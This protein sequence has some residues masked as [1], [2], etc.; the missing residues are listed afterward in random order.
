MAQLVQESPLDIALDEELIGLTSSEQKQQML[1]QIKPD[2]IILKPSLIG[3]FDHS[4]Q[5]INWAENLGIGWWVTSALESNVG[6]NAIAQYAATKAIS[7]PQGLGTGSLYFNNI[8]APLRVQNAK[9]YY[10]LNQSW[11][12]NSLNL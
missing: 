2:Y 11:S 7:M 9:L 1:S 3:G 6:L 5:W 4:Y 12:F 10:D 8:P